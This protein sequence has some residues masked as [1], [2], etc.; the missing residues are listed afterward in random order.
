MPMEHQLRQRLVHCI[1]TIL[2]LEPQVNALR[3]GT[4]FMDEMTALRD[5]LDRVGRMD[6]AEADVL[7]FERATALFLDELRLPLAGNAA[8]VNRVLQ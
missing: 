4:S 8:P 1:Q 2:D 3:A 5:C 7:R 6:I